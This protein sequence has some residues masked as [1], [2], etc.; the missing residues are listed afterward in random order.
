MSIEDIGPDELNDLGGIELRADQAQEKE[1][2]AHTV[3]SDHFDQMHRALVQRG[4]VLIEGPRGCGKTHLMRYTWMQCRDNPSLPLAIYVSFNRYLRLEPLLHKSS[5]AIPVF[6]GWVLASILQEANR[7]AQAL[8]PE[9]PLDVPAILGLTADQTAGLIDRLERQLARTE[10]DEQT[11]RALSIDRVADAIVEMCEYYGRPRAVVLMDDAALTLTPDYLVEFFDIVRVLKRA[12]ISPKASIYPGTTDFGPRFHA[13]QEGEVLSAWL[14]I[15]SGDYLQNMRDIAEKRDAS[16]AT[17]PS[18][19]LDLLAYAAFGIPRAYLTMLRQFQQATKRPADGSAL[20]AQQVLAGVMEVVQAHNKLRL[21]EYRSLGKKMPKFSSLISTGQEL[22][23]AMVEAIRNANDELIAK[24]KKET[25]LVVGIE[26]GS[27]TAMTNRMITLL[28][29][30]GLVYEY[31]KD[32]SHGDERTY[33]RFTPDVATLIAERAFSGGSRGTSARLILQVLQQRATKH[34]ARRKADTLLS[35]EVIKELKFDLP[36]CP[37]CHTAR[38]NE[39]QK[40]C[41]HCGTKLVEESTFDKCMSS[42]LSDVQGLTGFLV[43]KLHQKNI[44]TVF[45]FEAIRDPSSTLRGIEGIGK[46]RTT[47]IMTSIQSHIEEFLT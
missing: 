27:V 28:V 10:V 25:Q 42:P 31:P 36:P 30:A 18:D 34:P 38:I 40:F 35:T 4:L 37:R 41:H 46:K 8:D 9:D 20:T 19:A 11:L 44:D 45:Q 22:F 16:A 47:R 13:N 29:E 21:V 17:L 7:L 43:E 1:L 33:R 6:Q 3:K 32:V 2:R 14:P 24:E 15:E 39:E 12:K 5:D 23:L 26:S